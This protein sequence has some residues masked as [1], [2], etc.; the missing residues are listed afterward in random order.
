MAPD[1]STNSSYPNDMIESFRITQSN[2][3]FL[4]A[5]DQMRQPAEGHSVDRRLAASAVNRKGNAS[6][7][8]VN[9]GQGFRQSSL[10]SDRFRG[11]RKEATPKFLSRFSASGSSSRTSSSGND[12]CGVLTEG[13]E[14]SA[15]DYKNAVKHRR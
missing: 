4:S 10:N 7:E 5:V 3:E 1:S 13:T 14:T 6:L 2:S 15:D 8:D 9:T 12:G 11:V